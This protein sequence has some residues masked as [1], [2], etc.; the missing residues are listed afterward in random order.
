MFVQSKSLDTS[1][2]SCPLPLE[3]EVDEGLTNKLSMTH[4][5]HDQPLLLHVLNLVIDVFHK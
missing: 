5:F 1:I 2:R 3:R 4:Q